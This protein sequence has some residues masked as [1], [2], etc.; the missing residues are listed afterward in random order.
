MFEKIFGIFRK[1]RKTDVS[2][3]I[4]GELGDDTFGTDAGLEE[5]FDADT[6]SLET[7]ISA[8]SGFPDSTG[9]S[10]G[11]EGGRETGADDLGS[12]LDQDTASLP[13][14]TAP[15][16]EG[17]PISPPPE[18]ETYAPAKRKGKLKGVLATVALVV[19]GL[20]AGFFAAQPAI[21]FAQKALTQGPTPAEQ[22]AAVDAENAQYENQLTSYRA[23][24]SIEQI[25]A[26][27][28]ELTKRTELVSSTRAIEAKVENQP[29]VEKRLDNLSDQLNKINRD[30]LIQKGALSNVEKA[31]KQIEARN[32]YFISSTKRNIEQTEDSRMHAEIL[33]EHMTP[34]KI[35]QAE[36]AGSLHYSIRKNLEESTAEVLPSS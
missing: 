31:V 17:G 21:Q 11:T 4:A 18:M 33:K 5:D 1:R 26:I 19:I 32:N 29:S 28:N 36:A 30:L 20:V 7:G 12:L 23:V 6:I 22:L 34:E 3:E 24:G 35:Q 10:T 16:F 15:A 8:D 27:K 14:E 25:T 13:E 9:A 2:Q